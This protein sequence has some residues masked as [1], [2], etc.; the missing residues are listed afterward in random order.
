[1]TLR[2]LIVDDHRLFAEAVSPILE[3]LGFEVS[4]AVNAR[5]A[6]VQ[7]STSRPSLIVIDIGLPG[8]D[9][10]SLGRRLLEDDGEVTVIAVTASEDPALAHRMPCPAQ[11]QTV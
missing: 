11:P 3:R 9:G 8:E 6:T 5:E 1:M 10:L 4:S 7:I 2:A